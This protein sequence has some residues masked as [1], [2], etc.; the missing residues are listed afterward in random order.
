MS[1][2]AGVCTQQAPEVLEERS[3]GSPC[4]EGLQTQPV[5]P[6]QSCHITSPWGP[7]DG[8]ITENPARNK[9]ERPNQQQA[10]L[11]AASCLFETLSQGRRR[12]S[13]L[14]GFSYRSCS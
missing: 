9:P 7:R 2:S 12:H 3:P 11:G 1:F 14:S 13:I 8:C 5:G 6:E 10:P 4:R